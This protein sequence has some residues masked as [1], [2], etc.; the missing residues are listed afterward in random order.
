MPK[1]APYRVALL[2][3]G[4]CLF[5]GGLTILFLLLSSCDDVGRHQVLTLFFDG[6]PSL[7]GAVPGTESPAPNDVKLPV[8]PPVEKWRM[9]EPVKDCTVCHGKQPRRGASPKVQLVASIP[10]LC[11]Q[12]HQ[13]YSAPEGWMHGPVATG[14]CLLCHEPHKTKTESLL[15][16]PLPELCYQ[17]HEPQAVRAIQGHAELSGRRCVDCHAAHAAETKSLLKPAYLNTPAGRPYKLESRRRRYEESLHKAHLSVALSSDFHNLCRTTIDYLEGDL[18]LL[19]QAYLEILGK[20]PLLMDTE[21]PTVAEV[22]RQVIALQERESRERSQGR[23]SEA[24]L[25]AARQTLAA[26]VRALQ[27]HRGEQN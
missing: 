9:H 5:G 6:V 17:C 8:S 16:K 10:S 21:R 26:T 18:L 22:L 7:S 25:R 13:E 14:D 11:Y 1:L 3:T 19:A 15:R 2:H 20:G 4:L 27:E 23:E 12:C 24:T